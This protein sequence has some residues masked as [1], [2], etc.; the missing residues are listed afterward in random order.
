MQP[1]ELKTICRKYRQ[2]K[3]EPMDGD[4]IH[5]CPD[6]TGDEIAEEDLPSTNGSTEQLNRQVSKWGKSWLD[7]M[8]EPGFF[9]LISHLTLLGHDGQS[10]RFFD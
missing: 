10:F 8:Y 5:D 6:E 4:A 1:D 9:I 3:S 2:K 7:S